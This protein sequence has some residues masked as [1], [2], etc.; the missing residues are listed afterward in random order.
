MQAVA[1]GGG[2]GGGAGG[3]SAQAIGT[4]GAGGG[5]GASGA[6]GSACAHDVW[7]NDYWESVGAGGGA[8][9][10]GTDGKNGADGYTCWFQGYGNIFDEDENHKLGGVGGAAGAAS[11]DK[12]SAVGAANAPTYNVKFYADGVTPSK[13]TDTFQP[14]N[15][16]K[17]TLPSLNQGDN[18][19]KWILSIYGNV[20]GETSGH[21]GGPNGDVY[22]PGDEV[23]LSNIY[24]DIEFCAVYVG[25]EIECADTWSSG[26]QLAY[27]DGFTPKY[28]IVNLKGRKLYKDGY[29][30]TL[31][32]P[33]SLSDKKLPTTCLAGADIRRFE[34][35][36][37]DSENKKLTI[38]F[39]NS[40]E[41]KID[42]GVPYIIRWETPETATGEVINNPS[43]SNV[44]IELY[45]NEYLDEDEDRETADTYE[46]ESNGLRFQAQIAPVQVTANSNTNT[47]L[48]GGEN[49]LYKPNK[50]MWVYATRAYFT[51]TGS[52]AM[53]RELV[54]DFGEGEQ[55]TTYIDNIMVEDNRESQVEG[56]V[57]L[58][59]QRLDAPQKGINIINGRKVVIK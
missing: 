28:T 50:P 45:D 27:S 55:T 48:L 32:L 13:N 25:C 54:M 11:V 7:V 47:L 52:I 17:I 10:I 18:K 8:G 30:N 29:W 36:S 3:G 1:G 9:G 31:T 58:N 19:Y 20:L 56:I 26:Y 22:A 37:W 57:N 33:F 23:D 24:G 15:S 51:Y 49:K 12:S 35:A 34:N 16:T 42:A 2:G 40:N 59:G 41:E 53:A 44:S 43:F 46:K 21:C 6:S 4:G 5:G 39:S 14:S 38:N